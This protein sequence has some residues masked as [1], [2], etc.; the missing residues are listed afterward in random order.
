[1]SF[2][3]YVGGMRPDRT[4]DVAADESDLAVA[5][6]TEPANAYSTDGLRFA[7]VRPYASGTANDTATLKAY[8]I[9]H[10]KAG[11]SGGSDPASFFP[12][13]LCSV[14][15]IAGTATGQ[16]VSIGQAPTPLR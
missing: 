8:A 11:G 16:A 6:G 13:L 9:F 5:V 4:V 2:R 1:M 3:N 10:E 15:L 7:I 14:A 12:V